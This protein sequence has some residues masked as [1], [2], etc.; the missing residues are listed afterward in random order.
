MTP[1]FPAVF[2]FYGL[3]GSGK[4]TLSRGVARELRSQGIECLV[5]DGDVMR[6]GLCK[7][8]G[9]SADDRME[10]IRRAAEIALVAC[11]QG[12]VVLAAFI[13]PEARMRDVARSIL[14]SSRFIEI[15]LSCDL[16]TCSARDVKG[17]YKASST[18]K[19]QQFTGRDS[20]FEVPLSPEWQVDTQHEQVELAMS[21]VLQRVKLVLTGNRHEAAC[22]PL[23]HKPPSEQNRN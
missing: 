16:A 5:L 12:L 22:I 17:L 4:T 8:L 15:Y 3:S 23:E 14:G 1:Q 2:W 9:F 19:L 18:G 20:P 21:A 11:E 10:N 13:T 7:D 6:K